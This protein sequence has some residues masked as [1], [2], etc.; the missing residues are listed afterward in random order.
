MI[1]ME[2]K[3]NEFYNKF[4]V[5]FPYLKISSFLHSIIKSMKKYLCKIRNTIEIIITYILNN[6]HRYFS[7]HDANAY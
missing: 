4:I 6:F 3:C 5:N 2:K 7:K 1:F